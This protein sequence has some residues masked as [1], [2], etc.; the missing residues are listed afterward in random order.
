[1]TQ[2]GPAIGLGAVQTDDSG[3][4]RAAQDFESKA[5]EFTKYNQGVGTEAGSLQVALVHP[6]TPS[7]VRA[8][9]SWQT[10]VNG[11]ITE[12][13]VMQAELVSSNQNYQRSESV[14]VESA[15]QLER[16]LEGF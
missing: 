16:A 8:I 15:T 12:L 14:V 13:N 5:S 11:I 4:A 10:S 2:P 6:A 7:L 1:M 9:Q 3:M